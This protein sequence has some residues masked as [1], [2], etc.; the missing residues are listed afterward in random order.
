[1]DLVRKSRDIPIGLN[2]SHLKDDRFA[3]YQSNNS[4]KLS[5]GTS[6]KNCFDNKENN[7][8]YDDHDF[9]NQTKTKNSDINKQNRLN[10]IDDNILISSD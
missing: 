9:I 2:N 5:H 8:K 7:Y 4:S 6:G 10:E 1:M 3:K